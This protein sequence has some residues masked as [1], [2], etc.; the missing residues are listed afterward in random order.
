MIISEKQITLLIFFVRNFQCALTYFS[1]NKEAE[2][3][4]D[5]I[6]LLL[7]TITNQQSEEL[8]QINH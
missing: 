6:S 1:D 4:F 3:T 8:R 5:E 2:E 7:T